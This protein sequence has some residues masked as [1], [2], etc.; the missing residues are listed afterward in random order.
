MQL[1][2]YLENCILC[3]TQL[4]GLFLVQTHERIIAFYMI[5]WLGYLYIKGQ[6]YICTL[7]GKL[8]S[9]IS[10]LLIYYSNSYRTRSGS[11]IRL[12][13]TRELSESGK[14]AFSFYAPWAWNELQNILNLNALPTLSTFKHLL[15]NVLK[16][17]CNC[18][19]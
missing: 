3:I 15:H 5:L 17:T 4:Y 8:P 16:D 9:Y 1:H 7:L 12:K 10:N 6:S 14:C 18:F 13:V 2:L 11:H 19:S